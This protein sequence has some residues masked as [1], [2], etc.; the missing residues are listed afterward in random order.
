M[1]FSK[2]TPAEKIIAGSGAALLILSVFPWFS[3]GAKPL[4]FRHDAWDNAPTLLAVLIG[5]VMAAQVIAFR[6]AKPTKPPSM[7]VKWGQ[8]HLVL[9]SLA[10]A[11]VLLQYILGD[12]Y[13]VP[14]ASVKMHPKVGI[15]FGLVATFGLAYGGFRKSKEPESAPGFMG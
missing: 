14:G 7:K 1:D 8:I 3:W 13:G 11:M 2:L 15:F 5:A 9:G 6:M 4:E 10:F 12:V